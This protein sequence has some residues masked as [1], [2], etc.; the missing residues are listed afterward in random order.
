[1]LTRPETGRSSPAAHWSSVDLPEPDGPITAVKVPAG[2]ERLTWSSAVMASAPLPYL[3]VIDSMR[4]AIVC[5]LLMPPTAPG[6]RPAGSPRAVLSWAIRKYSAQETLKNP[7]AFGAYVSWWLVSNLFLTP[8][9]LCTMDS[10]D[11]GTRS[12]QQEASLGHNNG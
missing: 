7:L 12:K 3:L 9:A 5:A 2:Q 10:R 1:M 11:W 4:T 8:L 6:G